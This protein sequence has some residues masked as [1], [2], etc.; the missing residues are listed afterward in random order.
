VWGVL[1]I[2]TNTRESN[3]DTK[4]IHSQVP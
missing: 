2:R 1:I 3:F 4:D